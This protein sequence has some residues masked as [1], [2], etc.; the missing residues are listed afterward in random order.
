MAHVA[1]LAPASPTTLYRHCRDGDDE[2]GADRLNTVVLT[3]VKD[4]F[5]RASLECK[6]KVVEVWERVLEKCPQVAGA[7]EQ[8]AGEEMDA[9]LIVA[10]E[11]MDKDEEPEYV[12]RPSTRTTVAQTGGVTGTGRVV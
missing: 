11:N 8:S 7:K 5:P 3:V 2:V 6:S 4:T 1:P 10:L 9:D 12:A